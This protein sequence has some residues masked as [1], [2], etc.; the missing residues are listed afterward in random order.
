MKDYDERMLTAAQAAHEAGKRLTGTGEYFVA[1]IT[2]DADGMPLVF[3]HGSIQNDTF[4]EFLEGIIYSIRRGTAR[5]I[6]EPTI[7]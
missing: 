4:A 3:K 6:K 5:Q 1:L 2:V 7:N